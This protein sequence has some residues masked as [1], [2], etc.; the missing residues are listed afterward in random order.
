MRPLAEVRDYANRI[1]NNILGHGNL[2]L[3]HTPPRYII[4]LSR[5]Y[6]LKYEAD[7]VIDCVEQAQTSDEFLELLG[8]GDLLFG[9]ISPT[10]AGFK[11]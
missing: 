1:R 8:D 10:S 3:D 5:G 2:I 7:R 4:F 9:R 6:R 11:P